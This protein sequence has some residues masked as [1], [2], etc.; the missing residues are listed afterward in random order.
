MRTG[1][2]VAVNTLASYGSQAAMM[3]FF[4]LVTPVVIAAVG[5]Q[6]YGIWA[7]AY[8]CI[9][10]LGFLDFGF[11]TALVKYVGEARGS[12]DLERRNILVSTI[13]FAYIGLAVLVLLGSSSLAWF[14]PRLFEIPP[15]K[16]TLTTGVFALLGL[17]VALSLP[18]GTYKGVLFGDQL[19]YLANA[20]NV[21]GLVFAAVG[22]LLALRAG[23]GLLGVAAVYVAN[24]TLASILQAFAAYRRVPELRIRPS[25]F[26]RG[27]LRGAIVFSAFALLV[28]ISVFAM[29]RADALII[30]VSLPIAQVAVYTMAARLTEAVISLVKPLLNALTPVLPALAAKGDRRGL[31]K[32]V[33]LSA[34]MALVG[35]VALLLPLVIFGLD[36]FTLWLGPGFEQSATLLT[37]LAFATVIALLQASISNALAMTGSHKLLGIA[38]VIETLVNVGLSFALL[39]FWGLVGVAL[40][41][42]IAACIVD[43]GVLIP[44]GLRRL[45]I[46][47]GPFA[48]SLARALVPPLGIG[49]LA[50]YGLRMVWRPQSMLTLLPLLAIGGLL[51]LGV[52]WLSALT[53]DER[54]QFRAG[55]RRLKAKLRPARASKERNS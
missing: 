37:I 41:T 40:A 5:K 32:W 55:A 6:D 10:F 12:G 23:W 27:E 17:R 44:W 29:Q 30:G 26:R 33:D 36:V 51:I 24:L 54:E 47:R 3:A 34:R 48:L 38:L 20:S 52:G 16:A 28:N 2:R 42:L 31:A 50:L 39:R 15:S 49:G 19:A 22:I 13:F 4:L 53:A 1:D 25:L 8:A 11:A 18:L 46:P 43:L 7:M 45:E 35:G 21:I 14:A 9:G